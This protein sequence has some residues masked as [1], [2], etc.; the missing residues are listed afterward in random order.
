MTLESTTSIHKN[1][2]DEYQ[3][4]LEK[5]QA[6]YWRRLKSF[7][8]PNHSFSPKQAYTFC[9]DVLLITIIFALPNIAAVGMSYVYVYG[10]VVPLSSVAA[11]LHHS[12]GSWLVYLIA[13]PIVTIVAGLVNLVLLAAGI[14][15]ITRSTKWI[16]LVAL[17]AFTPVWCPYAI[18][19]ALR[20]HL[21]DVE[22][23]GFDGQIFLDAINYNQVGPS[24]AQFPPSIGGEKWILYE[25][26]QGVF[27][28]EPVG[29]D[30]QVTF[31]FLNE[32]YTIHNTTIFEEGALTGTNQ[33]LSFSELGLFSQGDWI[34]SCFAPA[35]ALKNSSGN[36]IVKTGLTAYTDCSKM[37]V[38]VMK[39]MGM[40]AIIV[41]IGRILIAL[42][43]GASCCTRSRWEK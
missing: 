15:A 19:A 18:E 13:L 26:S 10:S 40:D 24:T 22:C 9:S 8:R 21:W 17:L 4:D 23:E 38:C 3:V 14:N 2:L 27:Q 6:R 30:S 25:S 42:Q 7:L 43:N 32:T 16:Y 31:N 20:K 39:S 28:F 12:Q 11:A 41:A 35:V 33:P 29:W 5:N 37:N 1:G 36:V 34:R